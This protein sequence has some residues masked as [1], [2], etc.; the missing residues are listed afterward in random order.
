MLIVFHR[1][2][3]PRTIR[4][5]RNAVP[6]PYPGRPNPAPNPG[7]ARF[8]GYLR[9]LHLEGNPRPRV[10]RYYSAAPAG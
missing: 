6:V 9:R 4:P 7:L 3:D 8:A 10:P 2:M 5:H 1:N